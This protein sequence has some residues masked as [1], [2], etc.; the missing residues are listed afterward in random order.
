MCILSSEIV[1]SFLENQMTRIKAINDEDSFETMEILS[2]P[3][4]ISPKEPS[5]Q[6]KDYHFVGNLMNQISMKTENLYV[7]LHQLRTMFGPQIS[8]K[9]A[10]FLFSYPH[11]NGAYDG[12]ISIHEYLNYRMNC[13]F[14]PFTL[15][16]ERQ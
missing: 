13:F 3:M 7:C 10:L 14:S 8:L 11:D 6:N 4:N 16:S 12:S 5:N 1:Q 9:I 2:I 15:Y